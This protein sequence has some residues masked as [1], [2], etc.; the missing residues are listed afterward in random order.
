MLPSDEPLQLA[1]VVLVTVAVTPAKEV[2]ATVDV[3]V[4]PLASV[5]VSV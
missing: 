2:T 5:T 4:H 3:A 1:L